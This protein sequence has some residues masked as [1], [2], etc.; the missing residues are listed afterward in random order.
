M[1][2]E[3]EWREAIFVAR[4]INR[5]IGGIDMLETDENSARENRPVRGF[6]DIA[7]LYR[8]H[9]QAA[10]LEKCLRQEGIPY[11]VAGREDFLTEREVRA[12]L[13]FFRQALYETEEASRELCRKLLRPWLGESQEEALSRL[14]DKYRK[15]GKKAKPVKLLEEWAGEIRFENAE[16]MKKLADMSVLYPT[17]E[18]FL[19]TLSFGEDGDVRRNGGRKFTADAVTLMTLHGSKG[20]EFPVV[21]LYGMDQGRLPLEFG[22]SQTED[23]EEE[24]RLCYVGM[25]RAE[26]ELILT[27]GRTPSQF[28]K[29]I[30]AENIRR[31]A[32][33]KPEEIETMRIVQMSLFDM[34]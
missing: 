14:T 7:I 23:L 25:T 28:L 26:E 5:Q 18:A 9:R 15:K 12:T 3:D 13:Y 33:E 11:L 22:G 19:H 10:L 20:L 32:A 29:E 17:M 21:F 34:I 16:A 1:T 30:P 24:R 27:C 6:S 31:E 8:T 2:A 4:E